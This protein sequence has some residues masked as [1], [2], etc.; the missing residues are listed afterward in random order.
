MSLNVYLLKK[1][2]NENHQYFDISDIEYSSQKLPISIYYCHYKKHNLEDMNGY[3]VEVLEKQLWCLYENLVGIKH[4]HDLWNQV[5]QFNLKQQDQLIDEIARDSKYN[6]LYFAD[7]SMFAKHYFPYAAQ[8]II[9]RGYPNVDDVIPELFVWLQDI[10]WPG[11]YEIYKFLCSL[12][13]EA[14]LKYFENSVSMADMDLDWSWLYYLQQIMCH[15]KFTERDFKDKKLFDVL[16][17]EID[18]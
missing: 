6:N 9:K 3:D 1:I 15:F 4:P 17:Q 18:Y 10:N 7:I 16:N 13:K 8:V 11:S 5:E 2:L 14:I 12:P